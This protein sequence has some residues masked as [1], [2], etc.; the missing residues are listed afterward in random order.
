VA[1]IRVNFERFVEI[2]IGQYHFPGYDDFLG[3]LESNFLLWSPT[4]FGFVGGETS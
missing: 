2:R 4:S 1:G 3:H